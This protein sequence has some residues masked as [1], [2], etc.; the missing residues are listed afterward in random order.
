MK[1]R[2]II[3]LGLIAVFAV[4]YALQCIV[5]SKSP[6][7]DFKIEK[8]IDLIEIFSADNGKLELKK[9]SDSWKIGDEKVKDDE[10]NSI[11]NSVKNIKTLGTISK[12]TGEDA[13]E[14][15]GFTEA[16]K[17]SAIIYCDGK[18]IL[19][20]EIGKDAANGQQN[21]VKINGGSETMLATGALR[22]NLDVSKD[23][24]VE[25]PE[26]ASEPSD[27]GAESS[28]QESTPVI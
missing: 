21:Y 26:P 17:I 14:R 13:T 16:Q 1:N 3:L 2:K 20:L 24:L 7:K 11:L 5:S 8:E 6:V 18:K 28:A 10:I 9:F 27:S 15:Y 4:I 19:S 22:S 23:E 12:S 25:K